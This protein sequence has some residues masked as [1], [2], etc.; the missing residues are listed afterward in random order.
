MTGRARWHHYVPQLHLR[1]FAADPSGSFIYQHDKRTDK[2]S[3]RSIRKVAARTDYY[4]VTGPDGAPTDLL[5]QV[6]GQLENKVSPILRRFATLGPGP[7]E[8]TVDDRVYVGAYVALQ[9]SRVPSQLARTQQLA[10]FLGG[11]AMDMRLAE[12]ADGYRRQMRAF[13]ATGSDED[14]D[15]ERLRT[16][17]ELRAGTLAL[18]ASPEYRLSSI[19]VAV[20]S[21]GPIVAT[22]H[23]TLLRRTVRPWLVLG[24][25]PVV[26]FKQDASPY[27]GY[28]FATDGVEVHMP[29]SPTHVWVATAADSPLAERVIDF[30]DVETADRMNAESW[31]NA[32]ESVFGHSTDAIHAA[33][34]A[35]PEPGRGY[36]EP[37]A[38][39]EGGPSQWEAYKPRAPR[40]QQDSGPGNR[41]HQENSS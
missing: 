33:R 5:E 26:L 3:R 40:Q 28:G 10:D 29:I 18:H 15:A 21:V 25:T 1:L 13:G 11:A 37:L 22:M 9:Y 14:L 16:L 20:E 17:A 30:A 35:T 39:I 41:G 32:V 8:V 19:S 38:V 7:L 6:F 27:R 24:D 12:D 31:A 34:E 36:Q 2:T 23:W 4:T